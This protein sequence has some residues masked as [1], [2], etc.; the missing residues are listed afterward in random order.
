MRVSTSQHDI[1]SGYIHLD[2]AGY[3]PTVTA[4]RDIFH[5]GTHGVTVKAKTGRNG[6]HRGCDDLTIFLDI[7]AAVLLRKAL[8][9]ALGGCTP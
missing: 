8:D 4:E 9:D 3:R 5:G 7:P 1:P 2:A 6:Q